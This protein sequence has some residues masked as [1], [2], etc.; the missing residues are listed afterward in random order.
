MTKE[1]GIGLIRGEPSGFRFDPSDIPV[2]PFVD[3]VKPFGIGIPE[4]EKIVI[5]TANLYRGVIDAHRLGSHLVRANNSGQVLSKEFF[6][7]DERG[8]GDDLPAFVVVVPL[9]SYATLLVS[10]NLF[11]DLVNYRRDGGVHIRR[12]FL[13]M[14]KITSRLDVHFRNVALV[15]LD[16]QREM[17]FQNFIDN[18]A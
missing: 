3:Y 1:D 5:G 8:G 18:S 10:E 7:F 11:L 13:A 4:D 12:D 6:D 2:F 14:V 16:S 15:F 17:H 9:A